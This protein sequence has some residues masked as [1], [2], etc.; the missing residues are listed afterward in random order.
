MCSL[1][2]TSEDIVEA[3]FF[4]SSLYLQ[5]NLLRVGAEGLDKLLDEIEKD[6]GFSNAKKSMTWAE[7][8][9]QE[10]RRRMKSKLP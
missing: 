2:K 3:V 10:Q 4:Y 6:E 7:E 8:V 9:E 5:E 1:A